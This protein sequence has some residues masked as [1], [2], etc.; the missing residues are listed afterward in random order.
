MKVFM[1]NSTLFTDAQ[2]EQLLTQLLSLYAPSTTLNFDQVIGKNFFSF[3]KEFVTQFVANSFG[4]KIWAQFLLLFFRRDIDSKYRK[5]ILSELHDVLHFLNVEPLESPSTIVRHLSP[6]ESDTDV[7]K[8]YEEALSNGTLNKSRNSYLYWI[9]VHHLSA[10][11]FAEG[12]SQWLQSICLHN[13][14][15]N[16][17]KVLASSS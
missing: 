10:F 3:F 13:I 11:V 17:P 5:T 14:L 15:S 9:A 1:I 6:A 7:L 2:M 16:A 4:S 12:T 8:L